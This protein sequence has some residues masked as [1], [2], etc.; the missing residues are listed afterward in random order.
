MKREIE[1][2]L[3]CRDGNASSSRTSQGLPSCKADFTLTPRSV[4][5]EEAKQARSYTNYEKEG[6]E[7]E[8]EEEW[9]KRGNKDRA[10]KE[11]VME[12]AIRRCQ[13]SG[14]Y[15]IVSPKNTFCGW[16]LSSWHPL[17]CELTDVS[18]SFSRCIC[19]YLSIFSA[20]L[21]VSIS[22]LLVNPFLFLF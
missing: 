19:S 16:R 17:L 13:S 21:S 8:E 20:Q 4:D 1:N 12:E 14:L 15:N 3:P 11:F 2:T 7:Q 22:V 5:G 18:L 10:E 9:V 6:E